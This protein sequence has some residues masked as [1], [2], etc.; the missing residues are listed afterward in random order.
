VYPS[1]YLPVG[2]V[3][4][5]REEGVG[6]P[7]GLFLI[8]VDCEDKAVEKF[9]PVGDI[10]VIGD[11]IRDDEVFHTVVWAEY[12]CFMGGFLP[13]SN[14]VHFDIPSSHTTSSGREQVGLFTLY[15][16]LAALLHLEHRWSGIWSWLC[17]ILFI[18]RPRNKQQI[19]LSL[20]IS[21][22]VI[23]LTPH[24]PTKTTPQPEMG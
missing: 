7:Y 11:F 16:I 12:W 19:R 5:L 22:W 13:S 17:P 4:L 23:P 24:H 20:K 14:S 6:C 2:G 9:C 8:A 15:G 3:E 18:L 21:H 1:S 10:C